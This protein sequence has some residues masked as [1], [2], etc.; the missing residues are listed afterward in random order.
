LPKIEKVCGE[1]YARLFAKKDKL[2][3]RKTSVFSPAYLQDAGVD[4]F[5]LTQVPV[6]SFE[7]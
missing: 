7:T 5:R 1:L 6:I 3:P 4:V 2:L